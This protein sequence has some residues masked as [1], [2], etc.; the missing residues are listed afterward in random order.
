[1]ATQPSDLPRRTAG[2]ADHTVSNRIRRPMSGTVRGRRLRERPPSPY[3]GPL[4][5]LAT[6]AP[7][8]DR[9]ALRGLG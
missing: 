8:S 2:L 6:V 1:M 5:D 4:N 3:A 9:L 7:M